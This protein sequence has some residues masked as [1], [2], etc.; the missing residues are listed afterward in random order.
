MK[1][2]LHASVAKPKHVRM[3]NNLNFYLISFFF[4]LF[5]F[6]LC[7]WWECFSTREKKKLCKLFFNFAICLLIGPSH[8]GGGS[9][10]LMKW[11]GKREFINVKIY[12][13]LNFFCKF[14]FCFIFQFQILWKLIKRVDVK[15]VVNTLV[16]NFTGILSANEKTSEQT[17]YW[18]CN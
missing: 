10:V 4:V 11:F 13:K 9:E 14:K 2:R 16:D 17:L 15:K 8:S 3:K 1:L 18:F 12:S 7:S 5:M 6:L